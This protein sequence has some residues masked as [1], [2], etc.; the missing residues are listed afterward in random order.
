MATIRISKTKNGTN[1]RMTAGKGEDLRSVV[2]AMFGVRAEQ[3]SPPEPKPED[4]AAAREV[5][6]G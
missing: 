5:T 2:E 3:S 1:V 4:I 6:N